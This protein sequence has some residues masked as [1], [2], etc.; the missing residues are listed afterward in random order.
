LA[1]WKRGVTIETIRL[2]ALDG[3]LMSRRKRYPQNNSLLARTGIFI[4][5]SPPLV[6]AVGAAAIAVAVFLA[7]VPAINGGFVLDDGVLLTESICIKDPGGLYKFWCTNE[8]LDFWP[9]TN[10]TLWVEWRLWGMNPAG[11]HV[12]NLVLHIVE[13]VLIWIILRRLSIPGAFLA[14]I[15]FALHPVNVD[16]IAWIAQRKNVMVMLFFLISILWYMK[17]VL[18]TASVRRMPASDPSSH[19]PHPSSFYWLS[20]AAF[21]LAML[22]KTSLAIQPLV[23]LWIA[24]W[25]SPVQAAPSLSLGGLRLSPYARR[26][27][28]LSVPFFAVAVVLTLASAWFQTHGYDVV[29]RRAGFA[30]RLLGAGGVIWFYLCKAIV[31]LNLAFVYPQWKIEPGNFLWWLPLSAALAVTAVLW[32]Y[33]NTRV[34][35]LLF[36]WGFFCVALAPVL[37]LKDVG[38]MEHS[39]V[40][41]HYQHIAI[42]AVVALASA[43]F[44]HWQRQTRDKPLLTSAVPIAALAVLAFL[45]W[46][47]CEPYHDAITYYSA[48]LDKNP[49]SWLMHNNLGLALLKSGKPGESVPHFRESLRL[50][51]VYPDAHYNWATALVNLGLLPEAAE[52]YE[53]A[54]EDRPNYAM[55]H[56]NLGIVLYRMGRIQESIDQF[57]LALNTKSNL[58]E[59][60]NNLGGAL[61]HVG[62]NE[63]AAEHFREAIRLKPDYANAYFGLGNA[64]KALGERQEAIANYEKARELGAAQGLTGFAAQVEQI[65][66]AMRKGPADPVD[67]PRDS[68]TSPAQR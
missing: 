19:I 11:Y 26:H 21:V 20:L 61:L 6:V 45:T 9:A 23:L 33:R 59:A 40:A 63:E 56:N 14:A 42:I 25:L 3:K 62:R 64:C 60:H 54:L 37:G 66:S 16:S 67:S 10:S 48:A 13:A 32:L 12:T 49:D 51:P 44:I 50:K 1:L 15:V 46:K 28:V 38:F 4:F 34:R 17:A 30:E 24:W 57:Q 58:A 27:L 7:Y 55:A 39:L 8:P 2:F 22:S 65:I 47:Q 29:F 68:N 41:N 43:G 36:A 53:Q 31:P 18:P 52:Q 35:P 5:S